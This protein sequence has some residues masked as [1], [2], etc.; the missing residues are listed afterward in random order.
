M[1]M[2]KNGIN[3]LFNMCA[4]DRKVTLLFTQETSF[5]S[6]FVHVFNSGSKNILYCMELYMC[7]V[8]KM[9]IGISVDWMV[10]SLC[11]LG[12]F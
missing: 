8:M 10:I 5:F 4:C 9:Y 6:V 12:L 2:Q 3:T 1:D 7:D 11:G